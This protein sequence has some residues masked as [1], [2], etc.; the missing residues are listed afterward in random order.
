MVVVVV[1][2]QLS[3]VN[4]DTNSDVEIAMRDKRRCAFECDLRN[5][6]LRTTRQKVIISAQTLSLSDELIVL[7]E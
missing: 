1:A 2:V 4:G 6:F 7:E 5:N 3:I